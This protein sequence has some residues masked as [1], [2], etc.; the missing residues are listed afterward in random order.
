[1]ILGAGPVWRCNSSAAYLY[2]VS[3]LES[4]HRDVAGI[5]GTP[6]VRDVAARSITSIRT[7]HLSSRAEVQRGGCDRSRRSV[8][9]S[10][11]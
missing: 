7:I 10:C 5:S 1:M 6:M 8:V 2:G 3:K 4:D 11:I 9:S